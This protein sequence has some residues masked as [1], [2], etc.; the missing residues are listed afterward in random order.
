M[1][2]KPDCACVFLK[3]VFQ[4]ATV[5]SCLFLNKLLFRSAPVILRSCCLK[6]VQITSYQHVTHHPFQLN[7]PEFQHGPASTRIGSTRMAPDAEVPTAPGTAAA[8]RRV[9]AAP[10]RPAAP[11]RCSGRS[12]RGTSHHCDALPGYRTPKKLLEAPSLNSLPR[13]RYAAPDGPGAEPK[14]RI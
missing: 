7:P 1:L 5:N 10:V 4:R 6:P 14:P 9:T 8:Q 2:Q 13:G 3:L 12:P 11:L